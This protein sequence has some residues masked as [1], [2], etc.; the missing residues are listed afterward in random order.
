[1]SERDKVL[2]LIAALSFTW[3]WISCVWY[4]NLCDKREAAKRLE[5]MPPPEP[6]TAVRP[7]NWIAQ[8]INP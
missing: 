5:S 2:L 4:A 7:D 1:M 8:T 3:G 6:G